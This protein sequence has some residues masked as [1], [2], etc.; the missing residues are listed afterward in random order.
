MRRRDALQRLGLVAVLGS[1]GGCAAIL[2]GGQEKKSSDDD[3]KRSG[4]LETMKILGPRKG[5]ND[6]LVVATEIKNHGEKKSSATLDV[7]VEIDDTVHN[8][9]HRVTVPGGERKEVEVPLEV[10]YAKYE[11]ADKRSISLDLQ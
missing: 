11:N 8:R 9:D 3:P 5:E 6:N 7:T 10:K 2:E 1:T 4:S